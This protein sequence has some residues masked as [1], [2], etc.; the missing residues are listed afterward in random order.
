MVA[1][2]IFFCFSMLIF[3]DLSMRLRMF[4]GICDLFNRF[5]VYHSCN[6]F[7]VIFHEFLCFCCVLENLRFIRLLFYFVIFFYCFVLVICIRLSCLLVFGLV[8]LNFCNFYSKIMIFSIESNLRIHLFLL[9]YRFHVWLF[10]A[11]FEKLFHWYFFILLRRMK[12][13]EYLVEYLH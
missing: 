10:E 6:M 9:F 13:F 12:S 5:H 2:E 4:I 8:S 7:G 1:A 3:N 11:G